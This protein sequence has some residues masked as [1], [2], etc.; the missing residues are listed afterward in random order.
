[1]RIFAQS[2]IL[3]PTITRTITRRTRLSGAIRFCRTWSLWA[4]SQT[5][6][7]GRRSMRRSRCR[8]RRFRCAIMRRPMRWTARSVSWCAGTILSSNTASAMRR[9]TRHTGISMRRCTARSG[10]RSTRAVTRF[11]PPWSRKSSRFFRRPW[12]R[13]W[14][15]T[16]AWRRTGFISF[17]AQ[18]RSLTTAR[19]AWWPSWAAAARRRRR[20][21]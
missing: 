16:R 19:T 17:R 6:S 14:P 21:P 1:M 15:L 3:R 13:C 18:P 4:L 10:M 9:N 20:T 11:I 8:G 5:R 12:I 7:T 2:R